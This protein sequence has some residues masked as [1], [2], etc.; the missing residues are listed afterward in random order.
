MTTSLEQQWEQTLLRLNQL[1]DQVEPLIPAPNPETDWSAIAWRWKNGQM[2]A[3]R[4]PQKV[5]MADL[6]NLERQKE[7]LI[8]NTRQFLAGLPA[9][10]ALLWGARGTGK[11]SLVKALLN[12]FA[13]EGL[14]LIEVD[15]QQLGELPNIIDEITDRP[16]KFLLFA[17]DLSFSEND[18]GYTALK[19]ILDGSIAA[20]PDN[21]LIYATSNRRHL[22]PEYLDENL[23]AQ[24][25]NGE[26]HHGDVV[27]EKIS[28]SERFGLWLSF[29]PFKQEQYLNIVAHYLVA[30]GINEPNNYWEK[31]A[32]RHALSR[33]SRSGRVARQF[34][35]DY[36]GRR[37]LSE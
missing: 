22:V 20:A 6:K 26:I 1:M 2:N 19:A 3:V 8:S 25:V 7:Q 23:Q 13:S 32:L 33:G 17:D 36:A 9:N 12:E 5:D 15:K 34:A 14:R 21:L 10:N 24:H 4:H 31:E 18:P 29:H 35:A 27:E 28:L 37:Q 16:E 30:M 11:S